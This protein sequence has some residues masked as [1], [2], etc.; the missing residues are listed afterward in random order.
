MRYEYRHSQENWRG[1]AYE[2]PV[3]H[4]ENV[5]TDDSGPEDDYYFYDMYCED[6]GA[7]FKQWY[8]MEPSEICWC[9]KEEAEEQERA[10]PNYTYSGG[11]YT[12]TTPSPAASILTSIM[13]TPSTPIQVSWA[14]THEPIRHNYDLAPD[15]GENRRIPTT[16]YVDLSSFSISVDGNHIYGTPATAITVDD[17]AN[18]PQC[19]CDSA[20]RNLQ[21]P[22]ANWQA[23]NEAL[24]DS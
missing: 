10:V 7:V 13:A 6:C 3:C 20:K 1:P 19:R 14:L 17:I 15:F 12:I 4:S 5:E 9:T 11:T 24:S 2:C 8:R 22:H 23:I 21:I 16:G 18:V